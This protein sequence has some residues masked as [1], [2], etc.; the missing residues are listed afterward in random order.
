MTHEEYKNLRLGKRI[1]TDNIHGF[2]CVD[3]AKHYMKEVHGYVSWSFSWTA[4]KWFTSGSPFDST[5][6]QVIR[7]K[8]KQGDIIFYWASKENGRAGHVAIVDEQGTVIEQNG[9]W[10]GSGRWWD[11]IR[12]QKYPTSTSIWRYTRTNIDEKS[13]LTIAIRQYMKLAGDISKLSSAD[14]TKE[15]MTSNNDYFRAFWY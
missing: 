15:R 11:A 1:D 2:Q 6:K 12:I 3:L 4:F 13:P 9:V 10:G 7:W 5:R 8:P 14:I